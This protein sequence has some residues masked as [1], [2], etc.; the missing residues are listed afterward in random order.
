MI[1]TLAYAA[2]A[3]AA[4]ATGS[5]L[6]AKAWVDYS[7]GKGVWEINAVEVDPNHVDDYL[8]G[9]KRTQVPASR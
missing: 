5:T 3:V 1:R 9:L 6:V 2:A 8:T 7:P 4:I